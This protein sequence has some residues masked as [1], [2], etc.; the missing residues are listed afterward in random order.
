MATDQTQA[1]ST[2]VTSSS[3]ATGE[4][5]SVHNSTSKLMLVCGSDLLESFKVPGLWSDEHVSHLH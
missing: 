4:N 2:S 1:D 5:S 3:A